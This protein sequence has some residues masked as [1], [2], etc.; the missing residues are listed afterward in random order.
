MR[1]EMPITDCH[2]LLPFALPPA[3]EAAAL[4]ADLP[5]PALERLLARGTAKARDVPSDAFER[6]LPHERWLARAFGLPA[7]SDTPAGSALAPYMLL[8]DGGDPGERLWFCAQ[9]VHIHIARD[10][11]VL[12]D[13]ADLELADGDAAVL[14]DA[15]APLLADAGMAFAAPTPTRW[16]LSAAAFDKLATT[17]PLRACGHNVD[18]W[19]PDGDDSGRRAWL[20]LQNEIQM[21]WF[22]HP[23][24]AAREARGQMPVNSV[25]LHGG[26]RLA[27]KPAA[28]ASPFSQILS[29]D[30]ALRGLARHFDVP[31]ADVAGGIAALRGNRPLALLDTLTSHFVR[32]DWA[33]WRD[34]WTQ[35]EDNW[36]TPTLARLEQGELATLTLTLCG[37][38]HSVDVVV[39]RADLRKFWR[40]AGVAQRIAALAHDDTAG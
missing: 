6:T 29:D 9:P 12:T 13:P 4:F 34:A 16:Y 38:Y 17:S 19:M 10:H 21:I 8:A 25:W 40:R 31:V 3:R 5:L 20:Q 23:V 24:N 33:R 35:L 36:L 28:H 1:S 22:D 37:D 7:A 27:P 32:Q 39:R 14:R 2:L 11:L 30:A 18:I 15:A 26:G